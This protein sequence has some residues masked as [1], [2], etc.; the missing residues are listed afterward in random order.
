MKY[1]II[2]NGSKLKPTYGK[3]YQFNTYQDALTV[4]RMCYGEDS[5]GKSINIIK[6]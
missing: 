4:V 3:P 6:E 5:I 2:I 1:Y